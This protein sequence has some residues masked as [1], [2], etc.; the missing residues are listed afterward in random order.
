MPFQSE[1]SEPLGPDC[2]SPW[3]CLFLPVLTTL[4]PVSAS[5]HLSLAAFLPPL[6]PLPHPYCN[7]EHRPRPRTV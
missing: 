4:L 2:L 7:W 1:S 3:L 5:A 6:F